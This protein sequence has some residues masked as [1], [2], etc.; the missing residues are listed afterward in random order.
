MVR[1]EKKTS[2]YF[3]IIIIITVA[4]IILLLYICSRTPWIFRIARDRHKALILYESDELH[5]AVV[6][7]I[8]VVQNREQS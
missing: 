6:W 4:T 5:R 2:L 7:K 8:T 3:I 1:V